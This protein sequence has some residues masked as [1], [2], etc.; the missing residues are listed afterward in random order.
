M[1][2]F[3]ILVLYLLAILLALLTV[4]GFLG[5]WGN[6]FDLAS[7]FRVHYFLILMVLLSLSLG[8][9]SFRITLIFGL[10]LLINGALI[11]PYYL[12][13]SEV[14]EKEPAFVSSSLSVDSESVTTFTLLHLNVLTKNSEKEKVAQLI[15]AEKPDIISLL[16]LDTHWEEA[17]NG[18]LTDY[19]YR[20][21]KPQ[22]NNFGIGLYSKIPLKKM[23]VK[24]FNQDSS[25]LYFPSIYAENDD[26]RFS[27]LTTHPFPPI[28]GF[29]ARN[30]QLHAISQ[31][32]HQW[33]ENLIIVG[34]LNITPWSVFFQKFLNETELR[35]SQLG[36][37]VQASWPSY[38]PFFGIPIDHVLVSPNI[39]VLHRE[40]GPNVGSDHWPVIVKL[41]LK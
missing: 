24:Y 1:K 14:Q 25:G 9:K 26:G 23:G 17:L 5:A 16:E 10:C 20:F 8:I 3:L 39:Q 37:G 18:V 30:E 19:P 34:D 13:L 12:P 41:R 38:I 15:Q 6:L 21:S 36:Y 7:H 31:A 22:N 4:A 27:I 40:V 33:N 28:S 11:V 2:R 29:S 35:D 32:R